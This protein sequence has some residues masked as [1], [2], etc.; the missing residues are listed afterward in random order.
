MIHVITLTQIKGASIAD[1]ATESI[2]VVLFTVF[3]IYTSV[4]IYNSTKE[5]MDNIKRQTEAAVEVANQVSDIS[6][7]ILAEF[8]DITN[9]MDIITAQASENKGALMDITNASEVNSSEMTHQ[10]DLTQNIYAIIQETQAN[11]AK[12]QED[13]TE[14]YEEVEDGAK[15]SEDMKAQSEDVTAG[16]NETYDVI[17]RLVAEIQGYQVLQIQSWLFRLR[18][19]SW[20]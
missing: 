3:A 20:H 14:V 18:L 19:I 17:S 8:H 4:N 11:A 12:V 9:G 6:Q 15:M 10:S 5:N 7:Q 2:S 16:I 13:A 1:V